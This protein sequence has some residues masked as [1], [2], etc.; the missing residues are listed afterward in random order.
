MILMDTHVWLW[1][2]DLPVKNA[3]NRNG[4]LYLHSY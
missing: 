2:T 4:N 3:K 1:W